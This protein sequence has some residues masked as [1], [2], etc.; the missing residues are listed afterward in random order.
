MT[1][2]T[3]LKNVSQC[4]K[5]SKARFLAGKQREPIGKNFLQVPRRLERIENL[6]F[7]K[8]RKWIRK[9]AKEFRYKILS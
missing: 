4:W 9:I 8:L 5:N 2:E 6:K 1:Y 7:S 3:I